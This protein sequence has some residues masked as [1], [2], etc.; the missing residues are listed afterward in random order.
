M[1]TTT[2]VNI[3]AAQTEKNA[4][5]TSIDHSNVILLGA[6]VG[7]KPPAGAIQSS[8]RLAIQ[9]SD[10]RGP[11]LTLTATLT[12]QKFDAQG[13]PSCN[14]S[15]EAKINFVGKHTLDTGAVLTFAPIAT[16]K[17]TFPEMIEISVLDSRR[18]VEAAMSTLLGNWNAT[19]GT[20]DGAVLSD[21]LL[22]ATSTLR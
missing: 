16:F 14:Q 12:P 1:A 19:Y 2:F 3:P 21:L 13:N 8:H 9:G 10:G 15:F 20:S 7:Q 18:L 22:G 6:S 5:I 4:A 11:T 17:L